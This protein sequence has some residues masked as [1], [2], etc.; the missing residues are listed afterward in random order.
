MQR[1]FVRQTRSR[2]KATQEAPGT[3]ACAIADDPDT[4]ADD[5]FVPSVI[6][7]EHGNEC[8]CAECDR[9]NNAELYM[10][11]CGGCKRWYHFSCANVDPVT[12]RSK[13]FSCAQCSTVVPPP[14]ASSVAGRS[15]VSSSRRAQIARDLERLEEERLLQEKV[16]EERLRLVD[17]AM[18]DK[19]EREK[20]YIAR[21]HELLRQ[22]DDEIAS[23]RNRRSSRSSIQKVEAWVEQHVKPTGNNQVNV[24]GIVTETKNS[25][26]ELAPTPVGTST[27]LMNSGI[28]EEVVDIDGD[29]ISISPTADSITIGESPRSESDSASNQHRN[30]SN[31]L[32]SP[33]LQLVNIQPYTRL[34]ED[35]WLAPLKIATNPMSSKTG[36]IPKIV[37]KQMMNT[38][39]YEV[40]HRETN[41]LRKQQSLELQRQHNDEL[42]RHEQ[43]ERELED[44]LRRAEE[45]RDKDR[46]RLREMEDGL[47]RQHDLE[48]KHREENDLRRKR[49]MELVNKLKLLEQRHTEER[50]K[51]LKVEDALQ[52]QLEMSHEQYQTLVAVRQ[53]E[54]ADRDEDRRRF[55]S[56]EQQMAEQRELL[57]QREQSHPFQATGSQQ[58]APS[59]QPMQ[60]V[61]TD[62]TP[63]LERSGIN[64]SSNIATP[65]PSVANSLDRLGTPRTF[66]VPPELGPSYV[67]PQGQPQLNPL[68]PSYEGPQV[69]P[70]LNPLG[71][72]YVGPQGH[73]QFNP[74]HP[75][76][77]NP[78]QHN[79]FP[80]VQYG[81][82]H[83]QLA[84][85]HV[86]PKELPIFSGDPIDWPLF[87][88]SYKHS[89]ETLATRTRKIF[90]A[91]NVP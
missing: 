6:D 80:P 20:E 90:C 18:K 45:Q 59:A 17:K 46:Q 77:L 47:R 13:D 27:P 84:A 74:Y 28:N 15:S 73:P 51:L 44:H 14:S 64:N 72:P 33:K 79:Q 83:H 4:T 41:Q 81:P 63:D 1:S 75:P 12:V 21:K 43:R 22:Q 25:V 32:I 29:E 40:W 76:E 23:S 86:I 19:L 7:L 10:V 35:S 53:Q 38:S 62:R 82:T 49:E 69:Q 66:I 50:D 60:R 67:G 36:T 91:C 85:R 26:Q 78:C 39:P 37:P 61:S 34:L 24:E 54:L 68:G 88:S 48:T 8:E 56:L 16:E 11:Q 9:P 55:R 42:K 3:G 30:P 71:P 57:R 89:T 31:H 58:V 2:A 5:S 70:Q 65:C 87:I 52:K